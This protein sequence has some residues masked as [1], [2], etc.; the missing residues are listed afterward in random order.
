MKIRVI[1]FF[2]LCH[3]LLLSATE[4]VRVVSTS[5]KKIILE[6]S[7]PLPKVENAKAEGTL[8]SSISVRGADFVQYEYLDIPCR[9]LLLHLDTRKASLRTDVISSEQISCPP[10]LPKPSDSVSENTPTNEIKYLGKLNGKALFKLTLF[11]YVYDY[12]VNRLKI[13]T[14]MRI[15]IFPQD[16]STPDMRKTRLLPQDRQELERIKVLSLGDPSFRRVSQ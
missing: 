9:S 8:Y 14:A 2:I 6:I 15:L 7:N 3:F 11:P 1:I 16:W 12:Q 13:H 4:S 10:P 5:D